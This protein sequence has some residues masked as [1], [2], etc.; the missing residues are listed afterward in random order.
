MSIGPKGQITLPKAVRT[1]LK[2]KPKDKVSIRLERGKVTVEPVMTTLSSTFQMGSLIKKIR[3]DKEQSHT[4]WE[5]H[6]QEVAEEG[7]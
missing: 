6:A 1:K 3:S 5:E 4:A 2:V 7:L